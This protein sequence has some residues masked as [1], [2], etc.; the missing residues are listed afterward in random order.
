MRDGGFYDLILLY[1]SRRYP[2]LKN[3]SCTVSKYEYQYL[4]KCL[5]ND[6]ISSQL[7]EFLATRKEYFG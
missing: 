1:K 4:T 3:H 5:P 6:E 2:L 7:L